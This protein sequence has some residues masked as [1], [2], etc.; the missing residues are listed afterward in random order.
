MSVISR[1]IPAPLFIKIESGAFRKLKKVLKENHI[2]FDKPLIISERKV[3]ELG[4]NEIVRS[5]GEPGIHLAK[6][7]SISEGDEIGISLR[8]NNNDVVICIG[9]GRI[10]DLGKY[11]ATKA[12]LNYISIPTSPSN[13]GLASPVAV[14]KNSIGLTESLGVNMP[15]GILVDLDMMKSAPIDNIKAGTGDLLSN[16]SALEDW[17]LAY[18]E[19]KEGMDDFAASLAYSAADLMYGKFA[20]CQKVELDEEKF[21]KTLVNGLILSGIAMNIAG[22]SR[23]CSGAEHEISH[24]IDKLFPGRSMHGLQVSLGILIAEKLRKKDFENYNKFFELIGLPTRAEDI[25]LTD[26][27]LMQALELAPNTRPDRFT[28]LE[29]EFR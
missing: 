16:F 9:G 22:S 14:L 24:A 21:L 4:G 26:D 20:G 1:N 25:G 2:E 27:E 11:A 17:K 12:K 18:D 23:P 29:K 7:N 3:L 5:F 19:N 8:Q 10:L 15:M 13:D 28:I 6:D